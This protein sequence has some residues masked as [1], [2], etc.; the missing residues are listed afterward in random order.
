VARPPKVTIAQLKTALTNSRGIYTGAAAQLHI[1]RRAVGR[2]VERSKTLQRH[3]AQVKEATLDLAQTRLAEGIELTKR[4]VAT[5]GE[6]EERARLMWEYVRVCAQEA[7][8]EWGGGWATLDRMHLQQDPEGNPLVHL[9]ESVVDAHAVAK[10][11]WG[12]AV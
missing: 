12:A 9:G 10:G 6:E 8:L 7:G 1:D 5:R 11:W 2:H 3:V 4:G